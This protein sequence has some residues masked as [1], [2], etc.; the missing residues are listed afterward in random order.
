MIAHSL[1]PSEYEGKGQPISLSVDSDFARSG[2]SLEEFM[3]AIDHDGYLFG[4]YLEKRGLY[5]RSTVFNDG[6]AFRDVHLGIDLWCPAGTEVFCPWDG[7]IHSFR[8]N[9]KFGDYGP[10]IIVQ[11]NAGV[12]QGYSLYGHLSRSSLEG[13][14]SGKTLKG[15]QRMGILGEPFENV[16]WPPHLHFQL[17]YDLKG[18]EG[19][20]PG[21]C[22]ENEKD[23]F[24]GNCPDP[25]QF[26]GLLR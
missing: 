19:D 10:T 24:R 4:G 7:V 25:L 23:K 5:S 13:L 9:A 16:G 12:F 17:I 21:V 3:D 18:Y 6:H 15:G 8:D 20:Y 14:R 2:K 11:H 22:L 1:L 26:S